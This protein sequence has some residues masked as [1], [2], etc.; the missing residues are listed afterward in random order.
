MKSMNILRLLQDIKKK[1]GKAPLKR[2]ILDAY[3]A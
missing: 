3:Y 1:I 2:I